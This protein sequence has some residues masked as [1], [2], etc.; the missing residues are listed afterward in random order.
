MPGFL[1]SFGWAFWV[2]EIWLEGWRFN[3]PETCWETLEWADWG[4]ERFCGKA[5]V[6]EGEGEGGFGGRV[7]VGGWPVSGMEEWFLSS[8]YILVGFF[9]DFLDYRL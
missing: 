8:G 5:G 7:G 9:Q 3:E 4:L 2:N 1:L 6:G